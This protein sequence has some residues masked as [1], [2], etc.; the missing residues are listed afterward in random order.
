VEAWSA[1][2][3]PAILYQESID[4][5]LNGSNEEASA[6]LKP[7]PADST[8]AWEVEPRGEKPETQQSGV[9]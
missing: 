8:V 9:A 2:R 4:S 6:C 7:Y 3:I 5:W 1:H